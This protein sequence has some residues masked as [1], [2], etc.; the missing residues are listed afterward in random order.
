MGVPIILSVLWDYPVDHF[1]QTQYYRQTRY[2]RQ[3]VASAP[4]TAN[5][6]NVTYLVD[7]MRPID[8]RTISVQFT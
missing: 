8:V 6:V 4:I 2:Y 5:G 1:R 7:I 3:K